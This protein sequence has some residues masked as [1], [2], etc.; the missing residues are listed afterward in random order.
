VE[1]YRTEATSKFPTGR[2]AG[3]PR[4]FLISCPHVRNNSANYNDPSGHIAESEVSDAE[5]LLKQLELFGIKIDI[6]WGFDILAQWQDGEWTLSELTLVLTGV[7]DMANVMGGADKFKTQLGGVT[8]YQRQIDTDGKG[9]AHWVI[10]NKSFGKWTVVH[11]LAHA[12][13][14]AH[15]WRLSQDM[16]NAM[17]AGYKDIWSQIAHFFDPMNPDNWYGPGDGPP[18]CGTDQNFNAVEDFAESVTALVYPVEA[19]IN[20]DKSKFPYDDKVRGYNY[21]D[22]ASTP[23][24]TYIIALMI[25]LP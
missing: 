20:A 10:L 19:K 4:L 3:R 14:A 9:D 5:K 17:H 16:K 6:D 22:Y 13:D 2:G 21:A 25:H 15:G 7:Q 23:R 11:E 24:G 18:P 8:I 12:W 1:V